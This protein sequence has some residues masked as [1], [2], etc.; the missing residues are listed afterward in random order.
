M[1]M[2]F[3]EM[4]DA[5]AAKTPKRGELSRNFLGNNGRQTMR[6]N[7]EIRRALYSGLAGLYPDGSGRTY[8]DVAIDS[9]L[10]KFANG[11]RWACHFV[12]DR[13]FGRVPYNV[14]LDVTNHAPLARMT[15]AELLDRVEVLRAHLRRTIDVTPAARANPRGET[16]LA[17]ANPTPVEGSNEE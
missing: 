6:T 3:G 11:E 7:I 15:E 16:T 8:W 1:T 14:S 5:L 2:S 13:L 9:L 10:T 12:C 4:N 17:P